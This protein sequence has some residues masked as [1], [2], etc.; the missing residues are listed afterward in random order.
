MNKHTPGPWIAAPAQWNHGETVIVQS[1]LT[2][3]VIAHIEGQ[4]FPCADANAHLIAA[5]PDLLAALQL[6]I[7]DLQLISDESAGSHGRTIDKGLAAIAKA[8]V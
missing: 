1:E 5:A 3:E 8:G 4:A 2:A 6:A 7:A